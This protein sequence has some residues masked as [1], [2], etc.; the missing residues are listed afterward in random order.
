MKKV[1]AGSFVVIAFSLFS[2]LVSNVYAQGS[3]TYGTSSLASQANLSQNTVL[4]GVCTNN[5]GGTVSN[6]ALSYSSSLASGGDPLAYSGAPLYPSS[7]TL[8][9]VTVEVNMASPFMYNIAN[10][11]S[12]TPLELS[13][14]QSATY[15]V[16]LSQLAQVQNGDVISVT[17]SC[18]S[19]EA[20]SNE[21]NH[22]V[23]IGT[24]P[25]PT[26]QPT[27]APTPEPEEIPDEEVEEP[28][29]EPIALAK[30]F[31][32]SSLTTDLDSVSNLSAVNNFILDIEDVGQIRF[33]EAIDF[34]DEELVV[35]L[36][37]L[38]LYVIMDN[39]SVEIVSED[40]PQFN[41]PAKITLRNLNLDTDNQI[42]I[43]RDGKPA[44]SFVS[45][46]DY[47]EEDDVLTF[48][49]TGFSKYEVDNTEP[50]EVEEAEVEEEEADN[51]LLFVGIALMLGVVVAGGTAYYIKKQKQNAAK[52]GTKEVETKETVVS[53]DAMDD[54]KVESVVKSEVASDHPLE[55]PD[56]VEE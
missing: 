33:L 48:N 1:V 8:N 35:M 19:D 25:T 9:G 45:N 24:T 16:T 14:G 50:I 53:K 28:E 15:A 38:D 13:A 5:T 2:L 49:V 54:L 56:S 6:V 17:V 29:D 22:T 34:T 41:V 23:T 55:T 52:V 26:P 20:F 42:I 21:A 39:G 3:L 32:E 46:I 10:Y 47:D 40:I 37:K 30:V 11:Y 27:P 36:A 4:T 31:A 18:T 12:G 43:L 7:A 44:K 51:T